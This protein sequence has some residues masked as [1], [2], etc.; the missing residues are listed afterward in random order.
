[1]KLRLKLAA[2]LCLAIG[3]VSLT[4]QSSSNMAAKRTLV[5][6]G[7][8]LDVK[9]GKLA[10]AQTIIVIGDSIQAIAATS[11]VSAKPDDTFIDLTDGLAGNDRRAHP[12]DRKS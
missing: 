12:P 4:A 2:V 7:H 1:M 11:T 10:D 5:R 8:L 6:A 9:T 3:A